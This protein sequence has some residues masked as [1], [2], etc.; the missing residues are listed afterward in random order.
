MTIA[1]LVTGNYPTSA[2]QEQLEEVASHLIGKMDT[3]A[4]AKTNPKRAK[5]RMTTCKVAV[6]GQPNSLYLYQ[7]QALLDSLAQPYRQRLLL[8][9]PTPDDRVESKSF[10][11]VDEEKSIGL[12]DLPDS[13]RK[14]A[15]T[16][17]GESVCSVFLRKL[18]TIYVGETQPGGCPAKVRGAVK[19][20]NIIILHSL[21][22]DTWDRG[23]DTQ[24]RQVWGAV[25]DSYQF[26]WQKP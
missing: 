6:E 14:L 12:C 13:K 18:V 9:S 3:T 7:E 11:L 25:E 1:F 17:V 8:L 22:M 4:Q 16:E 10:K 21:G 20:T 19:I 23:F 2:T 26:R 5:V 15:P 24:D